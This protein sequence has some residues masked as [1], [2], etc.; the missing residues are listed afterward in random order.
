[1]TPLVVPFLGKPVRDLDD[2]ALGIAVE[3]DVGLGVGKD[4]AAHL[5]GPVVVMG[6]PAQRA[7]D[8]AKDD[9][10]V[11]E[12]LAAAL[13]VDDHRAVGPPTAFA[14]RRVASSWRSRRSAV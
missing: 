4:R 14:A 1:M 13:G 9:R 12:R 7:L 8:A 6:D 2:G 10:H 3:Q 5:V 11:A